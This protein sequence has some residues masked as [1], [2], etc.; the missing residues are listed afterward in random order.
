MRGRMLKYQVSS[1]T[2]QQV[3]VEMREGATIRAVG[4]QNHQIHVWAE[5]PIKANPL[6][7]TRTFRVVATG[8][9]LPDPGNYV[10]TVFDGP[11]VWHVCEVWS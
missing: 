7:V 6:T 5:T 9:D 8:S 3:T 10:G 4:M 11:W 1:D 2:S